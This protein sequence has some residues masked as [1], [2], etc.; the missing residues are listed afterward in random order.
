MMR[1]ESRLH[2]AVPVLR[3]LPA[4]Q[5]SGTSLPLRH[6]PI[7]R[8]HSGLV[9]RCHRLCQAH[10]W[11][12]GCGDLLGAPMEVHR[13]GS[14]SLDI[15]TRR[16]QISHSFCP[17]LTEHPSRCCGSR[18]QAYAP[19]LPPALQG[20]DH[21]RNYQ[22]GSSHM[23]RLSH[24]TGRSERIGASTRASN[25]W[26]HHGSE[27]MDICP[28]ICQGSLCLTTSFSADEGMVPVASLGSRCQP[29]VALLRH[30][31]PSPSEASVH[32]RCRSRA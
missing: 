4:H 27:T 12:Q 22:T 10:N 13:P 23:E 9:G 3:P 5:P 16:Y 20:H 11:R 2:F 6:A 15:V 7:V 19:R 21:I 17:A 30:N 1:T 28:V 24:L 8:C 31:S 26:R 25:P 18:A 29:W 14:C 32:L